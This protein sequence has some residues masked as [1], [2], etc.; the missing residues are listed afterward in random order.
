MRAQ[1]YQAAV[2]YYS[3]A[4]RRAETCRTWSDW[5]GG[6]IEIERLYIIIPVSERLPCKGVE[7]RRIEGRDQHSGG[8][9]SKI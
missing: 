5:T 4:L 1:Q 9:V 8:G 6:R 7:I 2:L 3:K